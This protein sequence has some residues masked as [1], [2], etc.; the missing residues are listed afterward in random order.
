[1]TLFLKEVNSFNLPI[2]FL[3]SQY[4]F[5]GYTPFKQ[6]HNEHIHYLTVPILFSKL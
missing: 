3:I 4:E 2:M 1:M 5:L 6:T